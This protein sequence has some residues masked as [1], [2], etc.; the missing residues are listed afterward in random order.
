MKN[1]VDAVRCEGLTKTFREVRALDGLTLSVPEGSIYGF[2]GPNGAGKTTSIRILTGLA[3]AGGGRAWVDGVDLAKGGH[4]LAHRIGYLPEE[5]SFYGWMTPSEY[6]DYIGRIF[7]LDGG[8]RD[9]RVAELLDLVGLADVAHR[10]I[11]GFS[12]GMRQRLG[13]AQALVNRP[14]VLFLDEP[15]SALDPAGRREV[16]EMVERLRGS[17]TVFMSTHILADVERVCD[18]IGIIAR[19]KLVTEAR[20]E[21]LLGRY[22]IP[23]YEVET[24]LEDSSALAAWAEGLRAEPWVDAVAVEGAHCRV[25]VS[26]V[27]PA[28]AML[29]ASLAEAHVPVIRYQVV[30]PSLEDVFL[31]L[32]AEE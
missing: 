30:Q 14:R 32:V 27:G 23:A 5:P 25:Q 18:T 13:L 19:G 15:A 21:D 11:V 12:R 28:G 20:R 2:L 10:R 26:D 4:D 7:G 3:R 8:Q 22:A 6:L 17:V 24:H 16:L 1:S 29:L 31:R 9:A